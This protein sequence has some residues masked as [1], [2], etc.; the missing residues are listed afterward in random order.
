MRNWPNCAAIRNF[1]DETNAKAPRDVTFQ[2]TN[3]KPHTIAT[4]RLAAFVNAVG[5]PEFPNCS[6]NR[7]LPFANF[8]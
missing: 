1:I 5:A 7:S 2:G 8:R 6:R 4:F 3:I